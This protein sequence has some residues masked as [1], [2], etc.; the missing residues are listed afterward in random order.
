M[1]SGNLFLSTDGKYEKIVT[2]L[3]QTL[4]K[5]R[6]IPSRIANSPLFLLGTSSAINSFQ[7]LHNCRYKTR[8]CTCGINLTCKRFRAGRKCFL[9]FF[10]RIHSGCL[11]S[12][13][14]WSQRAHNVDNRISS[15]S[16][17]RTTR[18]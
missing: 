3:L 8:S 10:D 18:C 1:P 2:L 14:S 11:F 4:L 5:M 7:P 12:R 15:G 9:W 13:I 6:N 16:R 17:Q